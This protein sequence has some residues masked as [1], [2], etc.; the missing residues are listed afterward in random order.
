MVN[1]S[2]FGV[3][4]MG[5]GIHR[6][7]WL[8]AA[9][10]AAR[11]EQFGH[12]IDSYPLVRETL[13]DLLVDLEAGMALTFESAAAAR[14]AS[15]P[16]GGRPLATH[17]HPPRQ[18]PDVPRRARVGDARP[19]GLRRQRLHGGLADGP[20][21]TRR[22][23]PHHLGGHREHLR[24]R[25]SP[26]DALRQAHEAVLR[27]IDRA[28]ELR[29]RRRRQ[30]RPRPSRPAPSA[31]PWPSPSRPIAYLSS[32]PEDLALLQL[33]RFAYLMADTLEAALLCEEAA[34][35]LERDGDAR[36]AAVAGALLPAPARVPARTR[37]HEQ[38]PHASSTCSSH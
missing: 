29:R 36:K 4:L 20:P 38:R 37:H 5:L 3:A 6:R 27:R 14:L 12:R 21:A 7:S 13:V 32:A 9:I 19:R 25:R 1:G 35:S 30:R 24:A 17:R 15:E 10:Y 31:G 22:P 18:A 23:V 33:R 11:R 34:W 26:G 8:E 2:R 16:R 28:L